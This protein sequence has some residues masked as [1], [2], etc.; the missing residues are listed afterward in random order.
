M[1]TFA[2]VN[3]QGVVEGTFYKPLCGDFSALAAVK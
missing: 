3:A 1:F 2:F